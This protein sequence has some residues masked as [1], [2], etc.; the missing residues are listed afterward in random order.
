MSNYIT[1]PS[2]SCVDMLRI[3]TKFQGTPEKAKEEYDKIRAT[4]LVRCEG[5]EQYADNC[6]N[7]KYRKMYTVP[8]GESS[9][10]V[11]Y[12]FNLGGKCD[13][14]TGYVEFNPAKTYPSDQLKLLYRQL[15]NVAELK[16]ETARWDFATD[17]P[18]PRENLSLI[19]DGRKYGYEIWQ[20]STEYLGARNKDGYT[21]LYDKRK[22]LQH[23][24]KEQTEPLTR[25]EITVE[26]KP[27]KAVW[28]AGDVEIPE[29]W[30]RV[31]CV[32]A[33][34]PE[35]ASGKLMLLM[36]AW[37]HGVPL[38]KAL[39]CVGVNQR[40][41][42]RNMIADQCGLLMPPGEYEKCR[43]S[44]LAWANEYGGTY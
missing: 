34:I 37:T 21:K 39:E 44:A 13:W 17:Y 9:I 41:K 16:R 24:G 8:A 40:T 11:G 23:Q 32:P 4:M 33:E 1:V 15:G 12:G 20:T 7:A 36:L 29:K 18:I 35:S 14:K 25:V 30:P 10:T 28:K 22:E 38:E 3:R 26:E 5:S 42:Y 6:G 19:R 43:K 27:G 2:C 31:V